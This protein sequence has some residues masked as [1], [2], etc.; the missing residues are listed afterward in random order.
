VYGQQSLQQQQQQWQTT[1]AQ[2][3][4]GPLGVQAFA[5]QAHF[6][7]LMAAV[8]SAVQVGY[9]SWHAMNL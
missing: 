3:Q 6:V 9:A 7:G 2:C 1:S 8:L 5:D 4:E